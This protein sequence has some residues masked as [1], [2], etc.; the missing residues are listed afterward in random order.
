M[1]PFSAIRCQ[2]SSTR[3]SARQWRRT[4]T[5]SSRCTWVPSSRS[6]ARRAATDRLDHA[7]ALAPIEDPLLGLG[8]GEHDR[9][10]PDQ[11]RRAAE[12]SSRP[13]P[14][15]RGDLLARARQA[16]A[17]APARRAAPARLVRALRG[18]EVEAARRQLPRPGAST[19]AHPGS[20]AR[21]DGE[22]LVGDRRAPPRPAGSRRSAPVSARSTL[23]T[24]TRP[25][26]A[27][28]RCSSSAMNGRRG[29]GPVRR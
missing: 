1:T 20:G 23:L 2:R 16:P 10:D 18:R 22:D 29:R 13:R 4:R 14:R 7:A 28:R 24:A 11:V 12:M 21:R 5:D 25:G 3:S 19:S 8:L 27:A 6:I 9:L 17:R 26:P 15:P